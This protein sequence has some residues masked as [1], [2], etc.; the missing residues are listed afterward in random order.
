MEKVCRT[1]KTLFGPEARHCPTH[2]GYLLLHSLV[3]DTLRD[4]YLVE[5]QIGGNAHS[6][7]FRARDLELNTS[8]AI[9]ALLL[10]ADGYRY[11]R[12]RIIREA[13]TYVALSDPRFPRVFARGELADG[14]PYYVYEHVNGPNLGQVIEADGPLAGDRAVR[15]AAQVAAALAEA[16]EHKFVHQ[17]LHPHAIMIYRDQAGLDIV[18]IIDFGMVGHARVTGDA[19]AS[20][21]ALRPLGIVGY[22]SP[23]QWDGQTVDERTD[24]YSLGVMLYEMVAATLPFTETDKNRLKEFVC[25]SQPPR[26]S[27]NNPNITVS[28]RLE[29]V[30]MQLIATDRER[31]PPRMLDVCMMLEEALESR[32]V[33]Q[34]ADVVGSMGFAAEF[35]PFDTYVPPVPPDNDVAE[36]MLIAG[37]HDELLPPA[38]GL[39]F[40]PPPQPVEEAELVDEAGD[41][42]GIR[43]SQATTDGIGRFGP[44]DEPASSVFALDANAIDFADDD[45]PGF[46]DYVDEP[47]KPVTP[48]D[49]TKVPGAARASS[50]L[51]NDIFDPKPSSVFR[52]DNAFG[53]GDG[54]GNG[55][56][57]RV[58]TTHWGK[59]PDI[60]SDLMR[61]GAYSPVPTAGHTLSAGQS[62]SAGSSPLPF[63][64]HPAVLQREEQS[65]QAMLEDSNPSAPRP[66]SHRKK[67]NKGVSMPFVVSVV[68]LSGFCGVAIVLWLWQLPS[69]NRNNPVVPPGQP[70]VA[71][72]PK[73]GPV[74]AQSPL[75]PQPA[76]AQ[77]PR[78]VEVPAGA[79]E[80]N[81]RRPPESASPRVVES[82]RP[83]EPQQATDASVAAAVPAGM[84]HSDSQVAAEVK[85]GP[86]ST[87][88]NEQPQAP[89]IDQQAGNADIQAK[90]LD[91]AEVVET[92]AAGTPSVGV[93]RPKTDAQGSSARAKPKNGTKAEKDPKNARSHLAT[94]ARNDSRT[95][96]DT[97]KSPVRDVPKPGPRNQTV[98]QSD[99]KEF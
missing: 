48:A 24:I 97:P 37:P 12:D 85:P 80:K 2:Q 71:S 61:Q 73:V 64:P 57:D 68:I 23:E 79:E 82:A 67:E 77:L 91:S 30:I 98:E 35:G 88:K 78:P 25:T 74:A 72:V 55:G 86:A 87:A 40:T 1:C 89:D 75:R 51:S 6:L 47:P 44:F 62:R 90:S 11:P 18:K 22:M 9:K 7:V 34:Q 69:N 46:E 60:D 63:R 13:E 52:V 66:L 53:N 20:P 59:P 58:V 99:F 95:Q 45:E 3:G 14:R 5:E 29:D 94:A 21:T 93:E 15:I 56:D 28:R 38:P 19:A 49:G 31:R 70:S 26:P 41:T 76:D 33:L 81:I 16:H 17:N 43:G 27:E 32:D 96:A 42:Q 39:R 54:R 50:I 84:A 8:V 4:R 83:I 10:D 36:A 92:V 65:Y